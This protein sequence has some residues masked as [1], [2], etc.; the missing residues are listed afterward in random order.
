MFDCL[1][2]G[3]V[4]VLLSLEGMKWKGLENLSLAKKERIKLEGI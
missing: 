4:E 1:G 3:L 2:K